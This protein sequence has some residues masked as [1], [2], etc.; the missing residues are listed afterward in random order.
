MMPRCQVSAMPT[1]R[2]P[3][4]SSEVTKKPRLQKPCARLISERF[5]SASRRPIC[6][7][8]L[9]SSAPARRPAMKSTVKASTALVRSVTVAKPVT[10]A[11]SLSISGEESVNEISEPTA[12]PISVRPSWASLTPRACWMSGMREYIAPVI[13][14]KR[15][16]Q[17]AS[18]WCCLKVMNDPARQRETGEQS[19]EILFAGDRRG[20]RRCRRPAAEGAGQQQA[21]NDERQGYA[22]GPAYA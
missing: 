18:L 9:I 1:C 21:E 16:K 7:L 15:K 22:V 8:R 11:P 4:A 2:T 19:R 13:S 3:A 6:T 17:A 12:P 5:S 20:D 14:E 10:R